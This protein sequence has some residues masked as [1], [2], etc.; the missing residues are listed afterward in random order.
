M[1]PGINIAVSLFTMPDVHPVYAI[2]HRQDI[3]VIKFISVSLYQKDEVSMKMIGLAAI[4]ACV[5]VP[6]III[7]IAILNYGT[8]KGFEKKQ[9]LFR[10]VKDKDQ[11]VAKL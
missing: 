9:R 3:R 2:W 4:S 1:D 8:R 11:S 10:S 5:A 6:I 7:F